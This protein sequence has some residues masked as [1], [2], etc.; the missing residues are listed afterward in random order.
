MK[1]NF[2]KFRV[3]V[4]SN[5]DSPFDKE[6]NLL[7][8]I[9]VESVSGCAKI[10]VQSEKEYKQYYVLGCSAK[11]IWDAIKEVSRDNKKSTKNTNIKNAQ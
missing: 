5:L 1:D 11:D 4:T 6:I 10:I 3:S 9:S 2:A 8:I 7:K